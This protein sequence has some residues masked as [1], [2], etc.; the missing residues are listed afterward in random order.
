[1]TSSLRS[2]VLETDAEDD[3]VSLRARDVTFSNKERGTSATAPD[4]VSSSTVS[5]EVWGAVLDED[6]GSV[7]GVI[8]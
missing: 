1:M 6:K 8:C 4:S 5:L 3:R 2:T 7:D